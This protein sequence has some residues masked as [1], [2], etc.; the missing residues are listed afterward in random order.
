MAKLDDS[1]NAAVPSGDSQV[2]E[3]DSAFSSLQSD[4]E[5]GLNEDHDWP[6][7]GE[8]GG[9]HKPSALE[10][11]FRGAKVVSGS[12]TTI[13]NNTSSERPDWDEVRWDK[14]GFFGS[15]GDTFLTVPA[16]LGGRYAITA[17]I[18][19]RSEVDVSSDG[20]RADIDIDTDGGLNLAR[21]AVKEGVIGAEHAFNLTA[22]ADMSANSRVFLSMFQNSG[23]DRT[24][25]DVGNTWLEIH[26]IG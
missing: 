25:N 8:S 2:A 3:I 22:V 5:A 6:G 10:T 14:G 13:A 16:G 23:S 24:L 7:S 1:W 19:Y 11:S 9:E 15:S 21:T 18:P 17:N 20:S 12:T 26:K 4:L